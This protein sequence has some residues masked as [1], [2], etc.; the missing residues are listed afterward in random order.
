MA[1]STQAFSA[2]MKPRREHPRSLGIAMYCVLVASYALNAADRQLFPLLLH[3]VRDAFHFSLADAG[4]LSTIFTLGLAVAGLPTGFA[5]ARLS[6]KSVLLIGI[7]IFSTGTA[8]TAFSRGFADLLLCLF[9]TGIGEAMQFTVIVAIAASYFSR[10]RAVAIGSVNFCFGIGAFAG[11]VLAS[12]LLASYQSWRVPMIAFGIAGYCMVFMVAL[13]VRPWL[14]EARSV[15]QSRKNA[16]GATSLLNLNS[17]ILII[18]S[19]IAGLVLYGFTGLYATFLRESL[20][21]SAK[22]AGFIT[23]FYGAGALV[24]VIGGWLGDRLSPRFLLTTAFLAISLVGYLCFHHAGSLVTQVILTGAFGATASGV[25]FVNL[26][27]Y[28]VKA[29]RHELASRASGLFVTSFYL[30]ASTAGFLMGQLTGRWGWARAE[31]IQVSLLSVIA[32][33][34]ALAIRP[35]RMCL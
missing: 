10:N 5:L 25:V 9:A 6:R 33:S 17:A 29:V 35:E 28:H 23:G 12:L 3:D 31:L 11:P 15:S 20:H 19:I 26:V 13:A 34:I 32:A 21:Y 16:G 4:L 2:E 22:Q 1:I 30:A 18:L 14:S 24:S 8:L 27:G 7:T